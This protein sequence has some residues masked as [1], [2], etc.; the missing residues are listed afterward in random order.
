MYLQY[1]QSIVIMVPALVF[2]CLLSGLC[3]SP[4]QEV[5]DVLQLFEK[6]LCFGASAAL[7]CKQNSKGCLLVITGR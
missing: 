5:T 3:V 2:N 1:G 6:L 7:D 4:P